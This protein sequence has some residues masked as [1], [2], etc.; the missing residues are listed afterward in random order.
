MSLSDL[1]EYLMSEF[2]RNLPNMRIL[3][4][5]PMWNGLKDVLSD[6]S[7]ETNAMPAF[8]N[9]LV[10]LKK[11]GFVVDMLIGCKSKRTIKVNNAKALILGDVY[12]SPFEVYGLFSKFYS[13]ISFFVITLVRVLFGK[14]DFIYTHGSLGSIGV[15]AAKVARVPVGQRLYGT[16]MYSEIEKYGVFRSIIRHPLEYLAFSMKK[17]FLIITNDGTKG[18]DVVKILHTE[19]KYKFFFW[20]NGVNQVNDYSIVASHNNRLFFPAR[21]T[22]WKR[23][24]LAVTLLSKLEE[25]GLDEVTLAYSGH[26]D[27]MIYKRE[28]VEYAAKKNIEN[29]I[30]FLGVLNE[31][32]IRYEYENCFAVLTMYDYSN[33]GNVFIEAFS[34]GSLIASLDNGS[35]DEYIRDGKNG[36]LSNDIDVLAK[37][38]MTVYKDNQSRCKIKRNAMNDAREFFL[39][40]EKRCNMEIDIILESCVNKL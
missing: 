32:Q 18:N 31:E 12:L 14:Y 2:I 24:H 39:S 27:D 8:I 16:F 17:D 37:N 9:P 20:T 25:F 11:Q 35:L 5:T 1:H 4:V 36:L 34:A 10:E 23:Q 30:Y 40:W 38:I 15:L 13:F 28:I 21:I 6:K 22:R 19:Q 26:I 7:F 33:L 29:R 3:Y